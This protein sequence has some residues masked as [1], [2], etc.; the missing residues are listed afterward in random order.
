M[1]GLLRSGV[2]TFATRAPVRVGP[3]DA[4]EGGGVVLYSPGRRADRYDPRGRSAARDRLGVRGGYRSCRGG[5]GDRG[6]RSRLG[7]GQARR[8][9]P[10]R[11]LAINLGARWETKRWPPSHFAEVARRAFETRGAS[12]FAIGAPEGS[13]LCSG[14]DRS[15]RPDSDPRSLGNDD[16]AST[17]RAREGVGRG[18][19]QTTPGR[20]ISPRRPG[21]ASWGF[22]RVRARR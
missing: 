22:I 8:P 16:L 6:G 9:G 14:V 11:G 18:P 3:A 7:A 21:R 10:G 1:Q 19:L 13:A 5:R 12:L 20:F 17:G 2:M 4:R 15:A